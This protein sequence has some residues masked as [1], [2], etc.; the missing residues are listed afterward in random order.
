M[1]SSQAFWNKVAKKY[2]NSTISDILTY[3]RKLNETQ[4]LFTPEMRILEFG[5][6][7]GSTAIQHAPF[8]S[9]IDATDSAENMIQIGRRKAIEAGVENMLLLRP[10]L[11]IFVQFTQRQAIYSECARPSIHQIL[12]QSRKML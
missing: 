12:A 6:G 8:V 4:K 9:H 10:I 7:T 3:E 5:C 2:S 11:P 1:A